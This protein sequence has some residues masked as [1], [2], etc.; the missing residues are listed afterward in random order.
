VL[1]GRTSRDVS[2][3]SRSYKQTC[4]CDKGPWYS[5]EVNQP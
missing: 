4:F 5:N 3:I 2:E 1:P